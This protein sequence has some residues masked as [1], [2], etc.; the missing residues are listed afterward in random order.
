MAVCAVRTI[1]VVV[2]MPRVILFVRWLGLPVVW[3]PDGGGTVG[4]WSFGPLGEGPAAE[5]LDALV[6]PELVPDA[7]A[8]ALTWAPLPTPSE[9]A[10]VVGGGLT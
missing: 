6:D 10:I 3:E 5:P 2:R 4:G 8:G 9:L 1:A 7:G